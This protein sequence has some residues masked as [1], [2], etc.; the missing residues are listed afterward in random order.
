MKA[1]L[2]PGTRARRHV[3]RLVAGAIHA[4]RQVATGGRPRPEARILSYH[5]IDDEPHRS[6]VTPQA[7]REQMHHLRNEGYDVVPLATVAAQLERRSGFAPRT[8]AITFDDGFADN[9][10]QAFP[11][12]SAFGIPATIF[13]TVAGIGGRL[14]FCVIGRRGSR[15]SPGSS[16]ARC[17]AD[18]SRW[19]HIRSP[20][21]G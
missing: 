12:L 6:C 5:R 21:R 3:R 10:L 4:V 16:C 9:Y 13:V 2:V 17:C 14:T 15:H 7:F 20:T 19:A 11:V 8:V 18:Q 1:L